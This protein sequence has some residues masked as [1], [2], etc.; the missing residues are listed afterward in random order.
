MIPK[1]IHYCWFGGAKHPKLMKKCIRSW[2]RILPDYELRIWTED[3][4]DIDTSVRY[5]QEAYREKKYAFVSD[6]V[7]LYALYNYG[8]VYLDTDVEVLK[9]FSPLLKTETIFGF[10]DVGKIST[11]F[12]AVEPRAEWIKELLDV[13][14]HRN[15]ILPDGR[16]D[17]TTNVEFISKYLANKNIDMQKGF[18]ENKS[19]IIYPIEY[20]SP[21]SWSS[22]RYEIT[23]DTYTIHYFAG[24]W[25]S[26]P[27]RVLSLFFTNEQI[28][29]IASIKEKIL[30]F[31]KS[32]LGC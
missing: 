7:R 2:Q 24:T 27:V 17:Q 6:Y 30:K 22:G 20:F 4:F 11:A 14:A 25:H 16:I 1:I 10:E 18:V 32:G 9:D 3:T 31:I 28:V 8:G 19:I 12:I 26:L 23:Q 15:F 21:K 29:K 13:Y 5:V